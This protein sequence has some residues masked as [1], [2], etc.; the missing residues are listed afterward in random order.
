MKALPWIVAGVGIGAA[1]AYVLLNE[2]SP[3][4]ST[5]WDSV[6]NTADRT[7]RWGS[8]SRFS[9]AGTKAAGALKEGI[10]RVLGDPDLADEG[11]ADQ[12]VGTVKSAAGTLAHAVG[13]TIHDLNR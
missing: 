2:P 5:G 4:T 13:D 12:A 10:G 6:E 1:V 7:W 9:G 8:K 11:V 3:Q